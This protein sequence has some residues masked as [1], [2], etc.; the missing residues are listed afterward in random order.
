[1]PVFVGELLF[2]EDFV[3]EAG[4]LSGGIVEGAASEGSEHQRVVAVCQAYAQDGADLVAD[5]LDQ[6]VYD[7]PIELEIRAVHA[8]YGYEVQL[9]GLFHQTEAIAFFFSE[10]CDRR[11]IDAS[12]VPVHGVLEA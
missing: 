8:G 1:M 10:Y 6:V 3:E 9:A 5:G 11:G 7:H 12:E 4:Y 2:H